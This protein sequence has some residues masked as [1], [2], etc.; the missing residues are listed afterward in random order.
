MSNK[1]IFKKYISI[2]FVIVLMCITSWI[3]GYGNIDLIRYWYVISLTCLLGI[4]ISEFVEIK[5]NHF[6]VEMCYYINLISIVVV[7]FDFDTT[8]IY[9]FTYGPLL[10]SCIFFHDAPIP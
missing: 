5:Y 3:F 8:I 4:R 9:P 6:L 10:F 7:L 2:P 1:K